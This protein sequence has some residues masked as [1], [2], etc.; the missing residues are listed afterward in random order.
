MS[1]Y[2]PKHVQPAEETKPLL[3]NAMYDRLRAF[4]A[5]VLPAFASAYYGLAATW[6]LPAAD[7]VVGTSAVIATF[8]GVF[9]LWANNRY[10]K[11]GAKYD[12][13]INVT[14]HEN[15]L[16]TAS[17]ELKNYENPSDIVEQDQAVFKVNKL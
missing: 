17:L 12:G 5:M 11:S 16:K 10:E 1:D 6:G 2:T 3:S 13:V 7:K 9:L 14:E 15:G 8:L 4:G